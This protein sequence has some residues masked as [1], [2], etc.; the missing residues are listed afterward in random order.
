MGVGGTLLGASLCDR[1]ALG[2]DLNS[3][4]IEIYKNA[5]KELGLKV[6]PTLQGDALQLLESNKLKNIIGVIKTVN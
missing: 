6:Q 5:S 1:R 2:I 3:D 4:F